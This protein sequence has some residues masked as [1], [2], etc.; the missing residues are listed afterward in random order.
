MVF[1]NS[2]LANSVLSR[3][4]SFS[5]GVRLASSPCLSPFRGRQRGAIGRVTATTRQA[6]PGV[7][8]SASSRSAVL[9]LRM[10]CCA[11][12]RV[13]WMLG[14]WMVGTQP[15]PGRLGTLVHSG[16]LSGTRSGADV[17]RTHAVG[18]GAAP[19]RSIP[20]VWRNHHGQIRWSAQKY[21]ISGM[22]TLGKGA[23]SFFLTSADA[24]QSH[25]KSKRSLACRS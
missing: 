2:A 1:T 4:F 22:D 11:V 25:Y 16:Q 3:A 19:P 13:G 17:S 23:T 24:P 18:S 9:S 12:C 5:S 7:L 10:I 21:Q 8:P 14:A 6:S 20:D 15:Q